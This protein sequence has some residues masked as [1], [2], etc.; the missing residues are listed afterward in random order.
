MGS[1]EGKQVS[2]EIKYVKSSQRRRASP[3]AQKYKPASGLRGF[4]GVL[5]AAV[6]DLNFESH[7]GL[8]IG[9]R[10]FRR[11]QVYPRL[12]PNFLAQ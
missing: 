6:L 3:Y 1:L 8:K 9:E 7:R 5:A 4:Y 12:K 10:R 2:F 11:L